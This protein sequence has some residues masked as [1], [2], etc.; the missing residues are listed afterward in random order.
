MISQQEADRLTNLQKVP[1]DNV[2]YEFPPSGG[3]IE[4]NLVSRDGKEEF[5]I[6]VNRKGRIS[7]K[8]TYQERWHKTIALLR[9]DLKGPPHTNPIAVA[10]VPQ[11]AS[12]YAGVTMQTPHIHIYLEN[13]GPTWAFPIRSN[14]F[15]NVNNLWQTL[16]DFLDYCHVAERPVIQNRLV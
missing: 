3:A 10:P 6:D 4:I 13:Y 16:L 12:Q 2:V 1:A 11:W 7:L 8:A 5:I 9:L 14:Q 15:A